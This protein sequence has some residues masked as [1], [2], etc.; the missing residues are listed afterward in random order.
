MDTE[1]H[2][3]YKDVKFND[4]LIL[5]MFSDIVEEDEVL[6]KVLVHIRETIRLQQSVKKVIGVSVSDIIN[7]VEVTRQLRK[8]KGNT[9][10]YELA[11]TNI[12]RKTAEK[13]ADK[14]QS[15]SL[16]YY[17][18]LKPYKYFHIT[19]RGDT[20]VVKRIANRKKEKKM[21]G[22]EE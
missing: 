15:M 5:D 17:T 8:T 3:K 20:K 21:N 6:L 9:Y 18:E 16:I 7:N 11:V 1:L 4:P 10:V 19:E 14:L 2:L 12:H 22:D 13:I